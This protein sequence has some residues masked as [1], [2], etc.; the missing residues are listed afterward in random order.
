[1]IC[2]TG[3]IIA[4][5]DLSTQ[6]QKEVGKT[7]KELHSLN[8]SSDEDSNKNSKEKK[9]INNL[10]NKQDKKMHNKNKCLNCYLF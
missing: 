7:R 3:L 1:M 5:E 6:Y 2:F 9:T 10:N 4:S 8:Y